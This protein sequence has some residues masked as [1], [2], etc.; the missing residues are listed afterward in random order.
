MGWTAIDSRLPTR[1]D[2]ECSCG[3]DCHCADYF[4]KR[5]AGVLINILLVQKSIPLQKIMHCFIHSFRVLKIKSVGRVFD[6][7]H[8][9]TRQQ[10]VQ[11]P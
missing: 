3:S 10:S 5:F 7:N 6:T 11:F 1:L 9:T 2:K 4:Y 8:F